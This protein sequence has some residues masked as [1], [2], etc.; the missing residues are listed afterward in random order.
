ARSGYNIVLHCRSRCDEAEAVQAQITELGRQAR[1]LQFDVSDRT[2]CRTALEVDVEQ[3][4]AYY[5]V[6]C[7]ASLTRDGVFPAPTDD[8]WDRVVP[9]IRDS[10]Y[11]VL[12]AIAAPLIRDSKDRRSVCPLSSSGVMASRGQVH[13]RASKGG[14]FGAAKALAIALGKREIT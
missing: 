10:V 7:N 14:V 9:T 11:N 6:V 3:H 13:Y 12:H 8:V 4:G 1:I 5:G 2:A